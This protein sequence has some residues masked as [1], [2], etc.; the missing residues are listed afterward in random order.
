MCVQLSILI[1]FLNGPYGLIF[2]GREFGATNVI[3]VITKK[4]PCNNFF[5]DKNAQYSEVLKSVQCMQCEAGLTTI[6]W[7]TARLP[8]PASTLIRLS[9]GR[10]RH[11]N[12][13]GRGYTVINS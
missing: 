8:T 6:T 4:H 10:G 13:E 11:I 5:V 9:P 1:R 3:K 7:Y 2:P 12:K